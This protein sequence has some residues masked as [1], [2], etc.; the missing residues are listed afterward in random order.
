MV[1]NFN[2]QTVF[3]SINVTFVFRLTVEDLKKIIVF[4]IELIKIDIN[5]QPMP[6]PA[7]VI[8]QIFPLTSL[9]GVGNIFKYKASNM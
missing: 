3:S 4:S 1:V 6:L 8:K 2:S 9:S 7:P 5:Y